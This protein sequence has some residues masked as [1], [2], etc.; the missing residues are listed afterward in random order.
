MKCAAPA[1]LSAEREVVLYCACPNEASAAYAAR[2]L[3]DR[4][5]FASARLL[6]D[7]IAWF[8]GGS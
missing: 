8:A 4:V 6:G 2:K 1:G 5:T 7:W 3:L